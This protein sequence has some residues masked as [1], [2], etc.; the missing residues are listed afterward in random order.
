[1]PTHCPP[2]AN[3]AKSEAPAPSSRAIWIGQISIGSLAGPVKAYPAVVS[4]PS[5]GLHQVHAGCG[6]RIEHR[7][8]CATHG[9]VA[10]DQVVRAYAYAPGDDLVLAATDLARLS[11]VDDETIRVDH[12]AAAVHVDLGLLSGRTLWLVP[13][14][15]HASSNYLLIVE[16]FARVNNWIV[17][18]VVLSEHRQPV[19]VHAADGRLM[20]HVLHWPAQRRSCPEIANS[21]IARALTQ[22]VRLLRNPSWSCATRFPGANT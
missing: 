14:H 13:A 1:M 16:Y 19:A 5:S 7:K 10:N 18:S 22:F 20:M 4:R 17:G 9:E 11:S 3:K 15:A 21:T 8:T 12:L 6:A 2:R